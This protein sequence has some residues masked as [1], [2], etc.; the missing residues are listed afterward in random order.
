MVKLTFKLAIDDGLEFFISENNVVLS[1]GVGKEGC[2][3]P[4]YFQRVVDRKSGNALL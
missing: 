1:Q 2:I 4:K 3:S